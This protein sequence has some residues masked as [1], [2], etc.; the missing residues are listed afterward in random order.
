MIEAAISE[1][2]AIFFN[3]KVITLQAWFVQQLLQ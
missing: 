2:R 1:D 3:T